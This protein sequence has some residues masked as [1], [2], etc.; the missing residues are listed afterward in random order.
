MPVASGLFSRLRLHAFRGW[1]DTE[2]E[3][4]HAHHAFW[5]C[6]PE[7]A[8]VFAFPPSCFKNRYPE[9]AGIVEKA[10][11][12]AG[13]WRAMTHTVS[14]CRILY[15]HNNKI[16]TLSGLKGLNSLRCCVFLPI[17]DDDAF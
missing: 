3:W 2:V 9:R 13:A 12:F 7:F 14:I 17:V 1:Q 8:Q 6:P 16:A 5:H 4:Q 10:N 11:I 15:A